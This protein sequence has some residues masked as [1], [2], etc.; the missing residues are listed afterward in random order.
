[1]ERTPQF[2]AVGRRELTINPASDT[3]FVTAVVDCARTAGS[4]GDLE[5]ALR[6]DYPRITVRP[7]SLQGEPRERWYVYRDGAWVQ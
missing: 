2:F 5:G 1:M 6:A 4:T 7:R 3:A